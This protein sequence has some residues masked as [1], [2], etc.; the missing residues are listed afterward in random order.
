VSG[1]TV[2]PDEGASD[3]VDYPADADPGEAARGAV[4]ALLARALAHPDDD[5]YAAVESGALDSECRALVER[6][7][8]DVAPPDLT[9]EDDRE[10]LSA[11]YNDLF[12][13]GHTV[14]ED[15]TDGTIDAEGPPVSPYESAYRPDAAWTDVN[16]D[17][18]RV[19]DHFGVEIDTEER[20]HHDHA[21]IEL[22]FAGYLCRRAAAVDGDAALARLDFLDRHLGVLA[23]GLAEAM[24]AEPGTGIYGEL[25]AFAERFVAADTA[26][27]ADRLEG[28]R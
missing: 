1:D 3:R 9:S 5:L 4:Y 24:A 27:L 7:G 10:T 19:Y 26:D 16:L 18:A 14:Y 28:E 8:L 20:D 22:E 11:R 13:V 2:P 25:A 12:V 23:D 17:L 15:R 21:R 6:S